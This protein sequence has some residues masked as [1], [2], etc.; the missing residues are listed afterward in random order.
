MLIYLLIDPTYIFS[1]NV[2]GTENLRNNNM[3]QEPRAE[4]RFDL[5]QSTEDT[6]KIKKG[7]GTKAIL[8]AGEL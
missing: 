5:T 7:R 4:V 3:V 1:I 8:A 6:S 2:N